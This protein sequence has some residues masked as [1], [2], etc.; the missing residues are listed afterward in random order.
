MT[1][2][3]SWWWS[4]SVA[5]LLS[6][7]AQVFAADAPADGGDS[8]APVATPPPAE[9]AAAVS[10]V[11][12]LG[13]G[14][15]RYFGLPVYEA[16]LWTAADF[17]PTRFEGH[18]FAL[19]LQYARKLEGADIVRRSIVEMRRS[20]TLDEGQA[21]AWEAELARAIPDVAPGDRLIGVHLP[22]GQTGF[23]HNGRLTSAV[24]DPAFARAFFGIWL[25]RSTS[26]PELR[27][28]LLGPQS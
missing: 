17:S 9:V 5:A 7:G 22:G 27:R 10:G 26:E 11:R 28:R 12:L 13:R 19:E 24:A 20:G 1:R 21:R 8:P 4:V 18:A 3:G 25:A 15:L 23:F 14:A 6:F 2:T 16:R